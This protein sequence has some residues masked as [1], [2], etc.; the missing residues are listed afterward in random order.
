MQEN[1]HYKALPSRGTQEL[2][3][4]ALEFHRAG[5][6]AEAEAI[7]RQLLA[8]DARHADSLHLL[9]M[10]ENQRGR[11]DIAVSMIRAAIAINSNEAAFHSNLGTVLANSGQAGRGW[12]MF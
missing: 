3:G 9:G 4:K 12:R 5:R 7:Y 11:T 10:I 8:A 2:L 6:L 1:F